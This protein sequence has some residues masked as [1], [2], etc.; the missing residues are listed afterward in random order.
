LHFYKLQVY[1]ENLHFFSAA[2]AGAARADFALEQA[3]AQSLAKLNTEF[4]AGK[5]P[6]TK[7]GR[8]RGL[9]VAFDPC[10]CCRLGFRFPACSR[11]AC[12][13]HLL[14]VLYYEAGYLSILF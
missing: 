6:E 13:P 2:R 11:C 4:S 1:A 9:L 10:R 5:H 14:I 8:L 7:Q 12:F 3:S